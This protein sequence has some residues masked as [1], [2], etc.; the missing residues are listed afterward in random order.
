VVETEMRVAKFVLIVLV[1]AGWTLSGGC[2]SD[3]SDASMSTLGD[4]ADGAGADPADSS[5]TGKKDGGPCMPNCKGKECGNSGCPGYACGHCESEEH[6]DENF[7]CVADSEICNPGDTKCT[8]G[9]VAVCNADGK[10][11]G[12]PIPCGEEEKCQEG[13]CV[14]KD[15]PPPE[16]TPGERKCQG[17]S[18][19]ECNPDGQSWGAPVPCP[20]AT[21]CENGN[22][23]P[24]VDKDNCEA[25]LFCML[26]HN[27]GDPE[28][29]CMG[30]CFSNATLDATDLARDVYHCIFD[31][32]GKWGPNEA[33]FQTQQYTDCSA[34]FAICKA[35]G[36]T[37]DCAGKQC[38]PD[39]C[40]GECGQCGAQQECKNGQCKPTGNA[41]NGITWQGCCDGKIL[42]YC[43]QG[44]LKSEDCTE[45]PKC[46]WSYQQQF[47][48]CGTQ[49]GSDPSGKHP[50]ACSGV[51]TPNC[52]DMECGS[53][54]CG[55]SCGNCTGG[56]ECVNG[57][58][59]EGNSYGC[60]DMAVC[61]LD[62]NFSPSCIWQC[63]GSGSPASKQLFDSLAWCIGQYCGWGVSEECVNEA[64]STACQQQYQQCIAD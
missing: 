46:G 53:D 31:H 32:C 62:C 8:D 25:V 6:C 60:A 33:C 45:D 24:D 43:E 61:A 17:N 34:E 20:E 7:Q 11:W 55:G 22:C 51:C 18:L 57:I 52:Q 29:V 40:G 26:T 58:C 63:Y 37:L 27:C 10:A 35:G 15:T 48:N 4:V 64:N 49:G 23:L 42:K 9:G 2:G 12:P 59:V 54:G 21:K 16:C 36:C 5:G 30:D 28:P 13:K 41:C 19:L 44:Q 14:D 39:G 1:V 50:K 38:G 56:K 3:S 47:Y